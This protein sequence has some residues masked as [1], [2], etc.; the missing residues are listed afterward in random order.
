[1][2]AE[3]LRKRLARGEKTVGIMLSEMYVPNIAR[4]L[5]G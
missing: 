4:L 1:M 3:L 5:A 2:S